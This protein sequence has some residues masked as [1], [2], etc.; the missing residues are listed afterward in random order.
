M[1][2]ITSEGEPLDNGAR[3]LLE[4]G[5]IPKTQEVKVGDISAYRRSNKRYIIGLSLRGSAPVAQ[6]EIMKNL[7][8]SI[9]TLVTFLKQKNIKTLSIAYKNNI[10][11]IPWE[12]ILSTFCRIFHDSGITLIA[13]KG[14]L[15]YVPEEKRDNI[16]YELHKSPIGGHRGVSKTFNRVRQRYY[17]ENLKDDIQRRIQQCL[18]CQLKGLVRLKTKQPMVITDCPG[19]SMDK[20]SLDIVGPLP[21]TKDGHE[22]ILTMQD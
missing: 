13:C 16:F 12:D 19:T 20:V 6:N 7:T 4:R 17:W 1:Y 22:C 21:K 14:T 18:E 5:K 9:T 3:N 11:N 8:N 15:K 2:F 10:E